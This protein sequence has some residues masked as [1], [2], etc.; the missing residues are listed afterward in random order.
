MR[1]RYILPTRV[2]WGPEVPAENRD[3]LAEIVLT[4]V[5]RAVERVA[6]GTSVIV[7]TNSMPPQR[8]RER[9][10]PERQ[11]ADRASYRLPS[12]QDQGAP[13]DV[14]VETITFPEETIQAITDE[15][16]EAA[17]PFQ[18]A[19]VLA[20][21]GN[22]YVRVKSHHYA[23][24]NNVGRA[25]VWGRVLFGAESWLIAASAPH[26]R[27][28]YY[29]AALDEALTEADLR[30]QPLASPVQGVSGTFSGRVLGTLPGAYSVAAVGFR[31]GGLSAPDV[32]AFSAFQAGV[33]RARRSGT[34]QLPVE[35]VRHAV[36]DPIDAL[37]AHGDDDAIERAAGLLAEL[38]A[39][40][41]STLDWQTRARYIEVLI[42]AWT[43]EAQEVAIVE[44]LKSVESQT[45]LRAIFQRLRDADLWDQLFDDLDNEL[46]SLLIVLGE[47]FG[48]PAPFDLKQVTA[49][50]LDAHLEVAPGIQLGPHGP[51]I[52][53]FD[54]TEVYEAARG[55]V[56]FLAGTLEGIWS[57][58][59][60]PD[61]LIDGVGQLAKL[62][63]MAKLAELGY[64]PAQQMMDQILKQ[65]SQQV[66]YGLKGA[67]VT[68]MASK[69]LTR[70][71][72][73][74]LWEIA[75]WFV[76][77]G[78]I[79][80]VAEG[81]GITEKLSALARLLRLLGLAERA[82]EGEQAATKLERLA[83]LLS[84]ASRTLRTDEEVLRV[85]AR[86]PE[87]DVGR[88]ARLLEG[89]EI[90]DGM[91]LAQLARLHPEL[92]EAATDALRKA[93]T[94]EQLAARA[95][96][97][98]DEVAE[99]F[100]RLAR[101]GRLSTDELAELVRLVP[102]RDGARFI[103][104]VRS[105]PDTA[106]G[107]GNTLAR[108]LL[109]E[110][111]SNPGRMDALA[112]IGYRSYAAM[113]QHAGRDT[114]VLDQLTVALA[115]LEVAAPEASRATSSRQLLDALADGDARA[116]TEVDNARRARFGLPEE[117]LDPAMVERWIDEE[118]RRLGTTEPPGAA[119]VT[120]PGAPP[121]SPAPT[122][123]ARSLRD[124]DLSGL[125]ATERA[126]L[127]QG[128]RRYQA[129]GGGRLRTLDDYIRFNYG[130]R[131][132]QLLSGRGGH[133][134]RDLGEVGEIERR[135]GHLL[136][137][138]LDAR[139]PPGSANTR[140]FPTSFGEVI[141]DHLPPGRS[142]VRLDRLGRRTA[143]AG[144]TPFSAQ[145][146]ADSKYRDFIPSTPQTRGFASLAR[147]SDDQRLVFYVRWQES[148]PPVQ[149]LPSG[150]YDVG[151]RLPNSAVPQL[152]AP[153]VRD[154]AQQAGVE[155]HLI[156]D[157][158]WR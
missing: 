36:F 85:L 111:A 75:S 145:F 158:L 98:T 122:V 86:L 6:T 14:P 157:P 72:W 129:R 39:A 152:V 57:L 78:E 106:F 133:Y 151:V 67:A 59:A 34:A 27:L 74:V 107:A 135:A 70:I 83:V 95:G 93:E 109:R 94:L 15:V 47:R 155:I 45:E 117:R 87:E 64:A 3:R 119:P 91:D 116:W 4:A 121:A 19:V 103:R 8:P 148:F 141:P 153:G 52:S 110:V 126:A 40:A 80:A 127:E 35:T 131:S 29:V 55:F 51:E 5:R 99:A 120:L 108:D 63:V 28:T 139:L 9:F 2:T 150:A 88:L 7:S 11:R 54:L 71:K 22:H 21:P 113:Y 41:F 77:A 31:G 101:P 46:W 138:V 112:A 32:G 23:T 38:N 53:V 10:A 76:G 60:H 73:A 92:G 12:F 1:R 84:R 81:A 69:I 65:M 140:A 62:I 136:E 58:I 50:L 18:D 20:L 143:G 132:G 144:G 124:V 102:E 37:I 156:S 25:A 13:T 16:I 43:F 26:G 96:G 48:D 90:R 49:L 118:I 125:S 128:W 100:A 130:R 105:V 146:V 44:I 82:V 24:T 42:R 61:R 142:S 137:R 97:L 68:G 154:V 115:D 17:P 123:L 104:A 66:V 79:K 33:A 149:T 30:V 89:A 56:R 134:A 147:Y 114:K